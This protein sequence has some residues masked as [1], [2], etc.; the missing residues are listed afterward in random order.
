MIERPHYRALPARFRRASVLLIGCGDVGGRIATMLSPRG[1][2]RLRL[3]G[4]IRDPAGA[5]RLRAM[6]VVPLIA[7]LDQQASLPRLRSLARWMIDLAPPPQSGPNDPRSA[8]LVLALAPGPRA[9]RAHCAFTG[10]L[11]P[12]A[13]AAAQAHNVP[14]RWVYI[15]TTGVY[16]N[17]EGAFFDETRPVAP[18]SDRA[19][20]R[21]DAERQFRAR[22]RKSQ[23]NAS[24]LRVPGI[25]AGDRLPLARLKQQLPALRD[26]DDVF[27]SHIHA[28]DL[29]RIAWTAIF[30][31]QP[32]RI[33]HTVDDS[34]LKMGQYF[35][36][37]ADAFGLPRPPRVTRDELHARVSPMMLSFMSESRRLANRRLKRELRVR[38]HY[39]TVD[40][41]LAATVV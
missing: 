30:R 26:E 5:P 24:I 39:P 6:G 36:R 40:S 38:L 9:R 22:T 3:L 28:D 25:Y 4:V 29:A 1:Q 33:V 16:G 19:G 18:T 37:V 17:C 34:G 2:H 31:G 15:S 11:R 27:T 12:H 20:R 21:V 13:S 10:R 8:R 35:D 7:D 23:V 32:G 41:L 14:N